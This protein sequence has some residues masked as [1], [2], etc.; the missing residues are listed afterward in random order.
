MSISLEGELSKVGLAR[1]LNY[2]YDTEQTGSLTLAQAGIKKTIYLVRGNPVQVES[3]LKEETLGKYLVRTGRIG[4]EDHTRSIELMLAEGIQ[5]GAALVKLGLL[6]PKELYL[7][8][9]EHT[10]EKLLTGFGWSSGTWSYKEEV[11]FLEQIYRF[12]FP[13]FV[14]LKKGVL[15][16]M[17]EG[18][19]KEELKPFLST[20]ILPLENFSSR[21]ERFKLSGRELDVIKIIYQRR[22]LGEILEFKEEFP[23]IERLIYLFLLCGLVGPEGKLAVSIREVVPGQFLEPMEKEI[24]YISPSAPEVVEEGEPPEEGKEGEEKILETYIG[25]K[26]QDYFQLLGVKREAND[27][28]VL[29]AYHNKL[30]EFERSRF[31]DRLS[32]EAEQK[33]EEINTELIKAY[34]ALRDKERRES[35]LEKISKAKEQGEKK[36]PI[37][38]EKYLQA[39]IKFVRERNYARAQEM[40]EKAVELKPEEAEYYAYLGWTIYCNSD[41]EEE[42]RKQRAKEKILKAME[43]NPKMDSVHVFYGKILKDEGKRDEA[44]AE[45]KEALKHNPNCREAQREINAYGTEW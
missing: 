43:M 45:F 25:L 4:E 32:L 33:L 42:E 36:E 22:S 14:L 9:K 38:A 29:N 16:Y 7:A 15:G 5:Q 41:I 34:E 44:L 26:A 11:N 28:E 27:E 23:F 17:P 24:P 39:G 2:L 31:S 19:I 35:Y 6:K 13:F 18:M 40:F 20:S 30:A 12:E 37:Y 8:V 3:S 21:I 1:V 10:E